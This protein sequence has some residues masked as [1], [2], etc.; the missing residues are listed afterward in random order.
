VSKSIGQAKSVKFLWTIYR[1]LVAT[2][3]I[4][5]GV[6]Q[7][8]LP[9]LADGT[10]AGT[11][12]SNTATATYEDPNNPGTRI[13]ATSNTVV[14]T[15][16]E[17]A[18]IT[19]TPSAITDVNGG[20]VL[21][22]D[23]VN[24]D[25][26][27]TNVGN[28]TTR[29]FIP[30]TATLTGPGTAGTILF[31]IDGGQT[32]SPLPANQLTDPIAPGGNIRV[33]VPV[34]VNNLA[35]SGAAIAVLIGNTGANDNSAG[36][37]NQPDAVDNPLNNEVRT[38]DAANGTIG[39]AT[40]LP[41]NGERE[42]SATQQILVGSQ[43][44][45]FAAVLKT[46]T[47][48]T[49]S[50]T[51]ALNDDILTYGLSLRVD[52]TPPA[53]STGLTPANLIGTPITVDGSNVNRVLVSDAIPTNTDL[54][55]TPTA[56]AGWTVVYTNSALTINANAANW[57]TNV[58]TIGGATN[59]T[60]IGFINNGPIA[61]G[62]TVT[63]FSFNVVTSGI[64]TT[65]TVANI[66][67]IFGRS[68]GGGTTLVYDESGD[69]T[70][71]NFNDDGSVGS[72]VPTNGVAN[73]NTQGVDSGNNNTGVGVGGE[74]N[75][76]TVAAPGSI[77]NG[78]NG[79]PAAV[80]T[81]NNNDDFTNRSTPIPANTTPGS[82]LNP[83]AVTFTN[84]INNPSTTDTLTNVLLVPD[85]GAAVGTVPTGTLVTLTFGTQT[86][87]Y[88][89]D[90]TD[91]VFDNGTAITIPSL[92]PGVSV[93]YTATVDL[94]ADTPLSTDTGNGFAVPIT[95]FVDTNS[96]G[97]PDA[98]DP[99]Q[100][101]TIDRVYTGFLRLVK[102][103]RILDANGNQIEGFTQTPTAT[104]IRPGNI[105]EYR[106][107][108]TNITT[109]PTGQGNAILNANNVVIT[110]DGT[111]APNN[112]ATDQDTNGIIDTS[113]VVGSATAANGSITFAPAGDRTGT[114]AAADV[115]RYVN[116]LGVI[117]DPG[118][119]GTFTFRRRIN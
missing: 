8:V 91:F 66:A 3:L 28:D 21:P 77:L 98:A 94:P 105:I 38:V 53:G 33:R 80:G 114:T 29:F 83:D 86:A 36:T 27:V 104:N 1:P 19:V 117:V 32:Y 51:P 113:N 73:P 10:A 4:A 41:T 60:R 11:T 63:G 18:G 69:Q 87:V 50:S 118:E 26:L 119:T 106:I 37:Q 56:P 24:Y 102:D 20:V 70:P 6:F 49:T 30:S 59:A 39:E 16:A 93:N 103:A 57:V 22:N 75:V 68:Q 46:R 109:P 15:V 116:A 95:T 23:V 72:N 82:T 52:A 34:T 55:G 7:L 40:G 13:N 44:Q 64:T 88:R 48:Y 90:G 108:Y 5:G 43:P 31:S 62:T 17:I 74:D 97:R 2:A 9:V 25:F 99:T 84:T 71:S 54:T 89:Y 107:R 76:F 81:T 61:A 79:Q 58:A 85:D 65:T 101:T 111:V 96:N 35:P 42:A 112:W 110:E 92:A 100:N 115:T 67:Q 45:A 78:P 12:I 14:V 47:G